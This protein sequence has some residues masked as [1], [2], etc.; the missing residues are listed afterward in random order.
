ALLPNHTWIPLVVFATVIGFVLGYLSPGP[1]YAHEEETSRMTLDLV[2]EEAVARASGAHTGQNDPVGTD[3]GGTY[4][5]G[6]HSAVRL[7]SP[8]SRDD[9]SPQHHDSGAH[10][11]PIPHHDSGSH[12]VDPSGTPES[13]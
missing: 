2:A 5:S 3:T 4:A 9:L 10:G 6:D 7:P 11:T 8:P 13:A 1:S 12:E